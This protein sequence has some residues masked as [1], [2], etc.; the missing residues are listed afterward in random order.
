MTFAGQTQLTDLQEFLWFLAFTRRTGVVSV[1]SG[2]QRGSLVLHDGDFVFIGL[3]GPSALRESLGSV[4]VGLNLVSIDDLREAVREQIA[5]SE[6]WRL[7]TFLLACGVVDQEGLE[8]GLREQMRQTLTRILRWPEGV[9]DFQPLALEGRGE[10]PIALSDLMP[11]CGA[12]A[13]SD[14]SLLSRVSRPPIEAQSLSNVLS[15]LAG[16]TL[17]GETTHVILKQAAAIL[18]HGALFIHAAGLVTGLATFG[19]PASQSAIPEIRRL[20]MASTVDSRINSARRGDTPVVDRLGRSD[21]ERRLA[22]LLGVPRGE[23]GIFLPL[24]GRGDSPL[25]IYGDNGPTGDPLPRDRDILAA[26]QVANNL[27]SRSVGH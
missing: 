8:G 20:E 9:F 26:L 6:E 4:L 15:R 3:D 27:L 25:L 2:I 13:G 23:T 5:F 16:Q 14:S 1:R 10:I 11:G 7:G 21:L 19:L 24:L 18:D 17:H 12:P 22:N